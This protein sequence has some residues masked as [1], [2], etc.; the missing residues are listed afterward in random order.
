VA[1]A[2]VVRSLC[3]S[4]AGRR[5]V[6]GV[7]FVVPTGSIY[8][9]LGPNG[10]GKTTVLEILEGFRRR[11]AGRVEVLG[12]DPSE[13]DPAW[14][15]RLGITCQHDGVDPDLSVGQQIRFFASLYSSPLPEA[16]VLAAVG[17]GGLERR[18]IGKLSGGQRRRLDLAL[19]LV[20]DPELAFLD[21]PTTGFDPRARR[22]AWELIRGL[23][24]NGRTVM[25]TT[26]FL[27]EAESLA[28]RIGLLRAG[29]LIAEGTPST[30]RASIA[31][32]C[33]VR[34]R[35]PD[36]ASAATLPPIGVVESEAGQFLVRTHE[37]TRLLATL[38]SWAIERGFELSM[39][40]VSPP[41][42]EDAYLH[43]TEAPA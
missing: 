26:H 40:S 5:V 39:L 11:D 10:A 19:A 33:V 29:R 38:S 24:R 22:D 35:L 31:S 7:S 43:L 2:V 9:L 27:D 8:A 12:V 6:D 32:P 23:A 1:D 25:L 4:Y 14:R 18:R 13:G 3:K 17:L 37:P 41:S 21:E 28:D 34:F 42:L 16:D 20:G 30:L 15:D 36:A